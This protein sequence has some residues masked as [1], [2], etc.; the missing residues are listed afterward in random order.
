MP[1]LYIYDNMV[2]YV[3][4]DTQE[5]GFIDITKVVNLYKKN[6]RLLYYGNHNV[7][8]IGP[9]YSDVLCIEGNYFLALKEG[10]YINCMGQIYDWKGNIV[11]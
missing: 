6:N 2:P 8:S 7:V 9:V 4:S 5:S 10:W 11:E 3:T 1:Y